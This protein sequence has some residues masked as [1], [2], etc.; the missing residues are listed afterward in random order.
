MDVTEWIADALREGFLAGQY[1]V[2]TEDTEQGLQKPYFCICRLRESM[3]PYPGGRM[4]IT[5]SF[6]VQYFPSSAQPRKECWEVARKLPLLLRALPGAQGTDMSAE[7][8]D[9]V[10]HFF[11]AYPYFARETADRQP[12]QGLQTDITTGGSYGN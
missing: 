8:T 11:A 10:L 7:V 3:E 12:M 4:R 5:P 6:D 1:G 9:N 2:F